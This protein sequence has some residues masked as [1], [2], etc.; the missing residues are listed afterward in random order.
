MLAFLVLGSHAHSPDADLERRLDLE[1]RRSNFRPHL[2]T[3][4]EFAPALHGELSA[5]ELER[6]LGLA[7]VAKKINYA[8]EAA[9]GLIDYLDDLEHKYSLQA[10]AG[11]G[12]GGAGLIEAT[13]ELTAGVK[14]VPLSHLTAGVKDEAKALSDKI[15]A[16]ATE[17]DDDGNTL[18]SKIAS[19][20]V[21]MI[22]SYLCEEG[23]EDCEIDID[24]TSRSLLSMTTEF[25]T[26]VAS[27]LAQAARWVLVNGAKVIEAMGKL[28]VPVMKMALKAELTVFGGLIVWPSMKV[29][30]K[31]FYKKDDDF[32]LRYG[33]PKEK[34]EKKEKEKKELVDKL[35]VKVPELEGRNMVDTAIINPIEKWNNRR[36][37][38]RALDAPV[39][40]AIRHTVGFC[41]FKVVLVWSPLDKISDYLKA[42]KVGRDAQG[43][44]VTAAVSGAVTVGSMLNAPSISMKAEY[45]NAMAKAYDCG[46]FLVAVASK[47]VGS[48]DLN[49]LAL[50]DFPD[51]ALVEGSD[52]RQQLV[53]PRTMKWKDV[54]P[55]GTKG[56]KGLSTYNPNFDEYAERFEAYKNPNGHKLRAMK[57]RWLKARQRYM[58][59]QKGKVQSIVD[60]SCINDGH[61]DRHKRCLDAGRHSTLTLVP[62]EEDAS[63]T[64]G[65]GLL[66][67]LALLHDAVADTITWIAGLLDQKFEAG[68]EATFEMGFLIPKVEIQYAA[69]LTV[70]KS[71]GGY[72]VLG[73]IKGVVTAPL[74][75]VKYLAGYERQGGKRGR[76]HRAGGKRHHRG[77]LRRAL[78]E[79]PAY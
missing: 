18:S 60:N 71:K 35:P 34:D 22:A 45:T 17:E 9:G 75:A 26:L 32:L 38:G 79:A 76:R 69:K 21:K 72:G 19:V 74:K 77:L 6:R 15:K 10:A 37:R 48:D 28:G 65:V 46:G 23:E 27:C 14:I 31:D 55:K 63:N 42:L 52:I 61:A 20:L 68:F 8:L 58:R 11:L 50:E 7:D 36:S 59:E 44:G 5:T 39:K 73:A 47:L 33:A 4:S 51:Q 13:A 24:G 57:K 78:Q 25:T 29:A 40:A 43:K 16:W 70:T 67:K 56:H 54:R 3:A 2:M 64:E 1:R 41:D 53:R 62:L 49:S 66:R 30:G 12:V